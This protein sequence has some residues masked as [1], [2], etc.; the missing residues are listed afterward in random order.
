MSAMDK[1]RY[2]D[3]CSGQ[4]KILW[5][6]KRD[7]NDAELQ[8]GNHFLTRQAN[9]ATPQARAGRSPNWIKSGTGSIPP[10]ARA[11]SLPQGILKPF[12]VVSAAA[13]F[14]PR[15]K[16]WAFRHNRISRLPTQSDTCGRHAKIGVNE[17]RCGHAARDRTRR[18]PRSLDLTTSLRRLPA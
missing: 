7:C 18:L 11:R 9:A 10:S 16:S 2:Q 13:H 15:L 5:S 17:T 14:R 4:F 6:H 3:L 12:R 8:L 1:Q